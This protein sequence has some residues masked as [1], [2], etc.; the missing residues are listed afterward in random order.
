MNDAALS[1]IL[2]DCDGTLVDSQHSIAAA[3]AT[4][5]DAHGLP[6]PGLADV[7]QAVGLSLAEVRH[8]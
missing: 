3:M 8:P 1:L 2:F 5:F 6:V 7:R 4:A